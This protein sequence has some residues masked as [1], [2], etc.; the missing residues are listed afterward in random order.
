MNSPRRTYFNIWLFLHIFVY[1]DDMHDMIGCGRGQHRVQLHAH[2]VAC[3]GCEE[4]VAL[5][6]QHP[7][8]D[9][10]VCL[11]RC[12]CNILGMTY[13][14]VTLL[15]QHP[16][17]GVRVQCFMLLCQIWVWVSCLN[18]KSRSTPHFVASRSGGGARAPAIFSNKC[19][20]GGGG[21]FFVVVTM[22]TWSNF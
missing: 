11:L 17:H 10:R 6:L 21:N 20:G 9:V 8:H 2:D 19:V 7:R 4:V 22:T 16:G 12:Y 5:L 18:S 14:S 3:E 13:V 1:R 15:L